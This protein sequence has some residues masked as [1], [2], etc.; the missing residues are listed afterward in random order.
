MME[1][2]E[3]DMFKKMR[4]NLNFPTSLDIILQLLYLDDDGHLASEEKAMSIQNLINQALPII[5]VCL[6]EYQIAHRHS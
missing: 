6:N 4:Y 5:Y 3:Q 2:V 1:M